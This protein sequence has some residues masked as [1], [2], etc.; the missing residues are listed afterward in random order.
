M[1]RH[2]NVEMIGR[3]LT[4]LQA[5]S[6]D[7]GEDVFTAPRS[8]FVGQE[9]LEADR[10]MFLRSP[11]VVGW[12][13]EVAG[14]GDY[15]TKDVMGIPVLIAR[16]KDGKLR[17]FLNG[18]RH[19]GAAVA[20][21]CGNTRKFICPYHAW[22]YELDGRL[23][24]VP[25]RAMFAGVDL[26]TRRLKQLP[27]SERCGLITVGLSDDVDIDTY[28][29][30]IAPVLDSFHFERNGHF[31]TRRFELKANWKLV[32][33]I[34][35]EGY[36]FR[37]L[38][39]GTV[40]QMATNHSIYDYYGRHARWYFP[41]RDFAKHGETPESEWPGE[42]LEVRATMVHMLFPSCVLIDAPGATQ[43]LRI[44]PGEKP[45]E[46]IVYMVLGTQKPIVTEEDRKYHEFVMDSLCGV[47]QAED[48]P[49]AESCQNGLQAGISEVLFGR[50]EAILQQ[51]SRQW[52]AASEQAG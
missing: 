16:A 49:A 9:R 19:R 20:K 17:A 8:D 1:S 23:T 40:D 12:A 36:H 35:F 10:A 18:C 50:N 30:P 34:N 5:D 44:Y 7:I 2:D 28:L 11:Q 6:L 21:D 3:I 42:P 33:S 25:D 43:L 51:L 52:S 26:K 15:T 22:T 27:V 45:G 13:G 38:H 46:T 32:V 41:F 29:D 24:G 31:E 37:F 4:H 48:F 47:L 39:S 14:I